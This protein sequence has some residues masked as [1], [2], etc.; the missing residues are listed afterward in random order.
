MAAIAKRGYARTTL[1]HVTDRAKLSRGIANFYF[2]SKEALL[3]ATL[4]H[5]TDEYAA[6]W[7][8]ALAGAGEGSAQRIEALIHAEF[9]PRICRRERVA[10]WFAFWG[11]ART[12]RA[13]SQ[14]CAASDQEYFKVLGG[15]VQA[16]IDEH[17]PATLKADAVAGGLSA[18]MT[19]FLQDYLL[20]AEHFERNAARRTCRLF[21]GGLLPAAFP[22]RDPSEPRAPVRIRRPRP[23]TEPTAFETLPAWTYNDAEF[24][25][26]ERDHIFRRTWHFVCHV[27]DIA[28]AGQYVTLRFAGERVFAI[29]DR[30]GSVRGF[31]NTCR[32][33]A[34]CVATG[35]SGW[36]KG[37]IVCPYHGWTYDLDGRL[38]LVPGQDGF[39]DL[40][41]AAFG[42]LP[43]EVETWQGLVF[44]RLGG[45]GPSVA[46]ML[47][48]Y[49]AEF[50]PYRVADRVAQSPAF[51]TA[52]S[53]ADWKNVM[54]N[55]LEG[56]H[57]PM[58]HPG[59]Q[60]MFGA[61]YDV[62]TRDHGVARAFS[63]LRDQPSAVWSER[64]YQRILPDV[65]E[66][67]AERRRA[68]V[69]YSLFP[70]TTINVAPHAISLFQIL[71]VGP[72]RTLVR[73]RNYVL[74][75][76]DRAL[77]AACW[78]G[79][80]INDAVYRE[81]DALVRA[82]QGGLE[83]SAYSVGRLSTRE[84]CVSR[85]HDEI[86]AALPV[87][88]L[89]TRPAAGRMAAMNGSNAREETGAWMG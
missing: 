84:V 1:A 44:V 57:I 18:M 71:P 7:R 61:R 66:L 34:A 89:R 55:Y 64:A 12:R 46:T 75:G 63:V 69:Y 45:T 73:G 78:L 86:R 17:G 62:E 65:P 22:D 5:L 9:H 39:P 50:A 37:A 25:G 15:L 40:D 79:G 6:F 10:A 8:A 16:L 32:H 42:L 70:S 60:R 85:F 82:V 4:K 54:D 77:R 67:P 76:A 80:R 51:W 49:E 87:A 52:E 26:L 30:E 19:G 36:M 72:G 23:A 56:Y 41:R 14:V 83:S 38:A 74:P 3:L 81:D 88:R 47:A 28:E 24:H 20:D 2:K 13:Y 35:A 31:H 11:E 58:G 33:R 27:N 29:R 21:L 59:L 68:W 43:V 48:P 53:A